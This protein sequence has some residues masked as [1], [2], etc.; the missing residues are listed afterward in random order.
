MVHPKP[1]LKC[2]L[3]CLFNFTPF[4][5]GNILH[6]YFPFVSNV[7]SL[8]NSFLFVSEHGYDVWHDLQILKS[9]PVLLVHCGIFL[10]QGQ[11]LA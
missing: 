10:P 8:H 9:V 6:A 7:Y 2:L 11:L 3:S 5:V 1:Y 4:T